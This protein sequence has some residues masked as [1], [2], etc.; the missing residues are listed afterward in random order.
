MSAAPACATM[1]AA[2]QGADYNA[3]AVPVLGPL[4]VPQEA[5]QL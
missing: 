3:P 2:P 4:D 1:L 5:L